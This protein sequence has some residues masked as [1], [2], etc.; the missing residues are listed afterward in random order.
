MDFFCEMK[1]IK[2]G[3]VSPQQ[4]ECLSYLRDNGYYAEVAHGAE[5][6]RNILTS[7]YQLFPLPHEFHHYSLLL[8]KPFSCGFFC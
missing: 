4:L 5:M 6:Q 2:G 7:I 8:G 3:K 1:R